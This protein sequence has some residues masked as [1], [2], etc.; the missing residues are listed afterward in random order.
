VLTQA[1]AYVKE[2]ETIAES[3]GKQ[4]ARRPTALV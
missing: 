1:G 3:K 2:M 4:W